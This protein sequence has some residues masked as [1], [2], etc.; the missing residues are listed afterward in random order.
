MAKDPLARLPR[1]KD[2]VRHTET[3]ETATLVDLHDA[4]KNGGDRH[5]TV[6]PDRGPK[7]STRW[8]TWEFTITS[9]EI[10]TCPRCGD[11]DHAAFDCPAWEVGE[12]PVGTQRGEGKTT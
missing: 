10:H 3:G 8:A 7:T 4:P 1:H 5:A 9:A 11:M 2:R 6:L 12:R